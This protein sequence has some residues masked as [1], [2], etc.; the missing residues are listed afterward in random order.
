[1]ITASLVKELRERTGA[2]MM[3]CKKALS[4]A[5]GDMEKALL[6]LK[7]KGLSTA[8]KKAERVTSEG[9]ITAYVSEDRKTGAIAE[10][11]CETDFVAENK[12]FVD[13]AESISVQAAN[14]NTENM[15]EFL[16]ERYFKDASL[17]V[18]DAVISLIT[19]LG[20]NICIKRFKKLSAEKGIIFGYIHNAGRIGV[21]VKLYS[22][23]TGPYFEEIAK[24]IAMQV[25]ASIP[26]YISREEIPEDKLEAIHQEF[27]SEALLS[28]KPQT[29][30]DRIV[31]GKLSKY[32]KEKCL[33]EQPWIKDEDI[34]ISSYLGEAS[35]KL[36]TSIAVSGF[37]RFERGEE[38]N[39]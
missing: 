12:G 35:K 28:G 5:E 29:I 8:A 37:A 15:D 13:L 39:R 25:A 27:M 2:G 30:A 16:N 11:S 21:L 18:K 36:G 32:Y 4:D 34:D 23:G 1:M 24:E 14:T 9:L 33:L 7:E 26:L 10:V 6:V 3:D 22:D 38:I 31:S 17:T 19:K 20:E